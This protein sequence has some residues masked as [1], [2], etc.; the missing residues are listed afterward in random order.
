MLNAKKHNGYESYTEIGICSPEVWKQASVRF[1]EYRLKQVILPAEITDTS[2]TL[3]DEK[4]VITLDFALD[5]SVYDQTAALWTGCTCSEYLKTVKA[6]VLFSMGRYIVDT[7]QKIVRM[8]IQLGKTPSGTPVVPP[9]CRE[10]LLD[11]LTMLPGFTLEKDW[12]MEHLDAKGPKHSRILADFSDYLS[13]EEALSAHWKAADTAER[14]RIFPI[15]L[16][17]NLTVILPLRPTEFILTPRNCLNTRDDRYYMTVRRTRL[18][19]NRRFVSYKIKDDYEC[20]TYEIPGCL[21]EEIDWYLKQTEALPQPTLDT[22]FVPQN[23]NSYLNYSQMRTLLNTVL[24]ELTGRNGHI[25]LGD[26]RHLS[27]IS[28]ILSGDTPSVCKALANHSNIETSMGY[29]ANMSSL[30]G[31]NVMHFLFDNAAAAIHL[32]ANPVLPRTDMLRVKDGSCDCQKIDMLDPFEC[33]KYWDLENGPGSCISCPHFIP[34]SPALR[35]DLKNRL[36]GDIEADCDFLMDS[37][38]MLRKSMGRMTK[39]EEQLKQLRSDTLKY[40]LISKEQRCVN[41]ETGKT[42]TA[43]DR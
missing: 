13:F 25:H 12:M 30:T 14:I 7:L 32:P 42:E 24:L 5:E 43:L 28:L 31:C 4:H 10:F 26:T 38:E 15:Y 17:W 34:D 35:I 8:L 9:D 18:K 1:N 40:L 16:W 3:T 36:R 19:D 39:I 11:F 20:F 23:E 37:I 41:D 33:V 29:Y 22:L 2:W 6:F 27:M 21:A